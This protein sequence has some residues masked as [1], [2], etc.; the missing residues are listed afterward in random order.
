MSL[1]SYRAAAER[2]EPHPNCEQSLVDRC[3]PSLAVLDECGIHFFT[4]SFHV[5][6]ECVWNQWL[7]YPHV[8]SVTALPRKHRA[9]AIKAI[10]E[11]LSAVRDSI[12]EAFGDSV[13]M[14]DLDGS[15]LLYV[16][17]SRGPTTGWGIHCEVV[18]VIAED[19][20]D[21]AL[22]LR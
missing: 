1:V 21:L 18:A 9:S 15:A 22:R 10:G 17:V 3:L 2:G 19:H 4:A 7:D 20:P 6:E 16:T 11:V 12:H 14:D 13:E 8:L 5:K